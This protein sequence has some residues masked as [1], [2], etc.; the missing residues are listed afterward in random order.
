M[1]ELL[2]AQVDAASLCNVASL[3]AFGFAVALLA[4]VAVFWA[5]LLAVVA[6]HMGPLALS[7]GAASALAIALRW[8]VVSELKDGS[9]AASPVEGARAHA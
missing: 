7:W 6:Q 8:F 1:N 2:P 5:A 3:A 9:D 4:R